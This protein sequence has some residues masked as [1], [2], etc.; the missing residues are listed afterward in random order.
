M[1]PERRRLEVTTTAGRGER[2]NGGVW[3]KSTRRRPRVCQQAQWGGPLQWKEGQGIQWTCLNAKIR[4]IN[5]AE[6]CE[7]GKKQSTA[8]L[9]TEKV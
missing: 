4:Q 8:D 2:Q 3:V 9:A 1:K 6:T 7:R 5:V